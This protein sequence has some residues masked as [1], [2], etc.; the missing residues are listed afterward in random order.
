MKKRPKAVREGAPES[1]GELDDRIHD[2]LIEMG[3]LIPRTEEDVRLAEAALEKVECRPLPPELADPY[4]LIH[5]LDVDD[6][7]NDGPLKGIV[8]AAK[9][10][11]LSNKQLA[12]AA[13]LTV[14]LITMFD[15]GMISTKRLPRVVVSRLA[16]AIGSTAER[17]IEYLQAGPRFALDMNFKADDTPEI[18]EPQDFREAVLDDPSIDQELRDHLLSLAAGEE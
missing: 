3:W 16:E 11:G 14:V 4:R 6:V 13:K 15:R 12:A 8:A 5:R 10:R 9:E 2:S 17:V 18:E 7:V 1:A